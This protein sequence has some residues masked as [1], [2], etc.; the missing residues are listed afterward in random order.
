MRALTINAETHEIK[1]HAVDTSDAGPGMLAFMQKAVG[2]YI[3]RATE[4]KNGDSIFVNEEG[5]LE[6]PRFFFEVEGG[7]Q[8]FAG[9]GVVVGGEDEDPQP[10]P[11]RLVSQFPPEGHHRQAQRGV[12]NKL[13]RLCP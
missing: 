2:G 5:L 13:A 9:N 11:V 7:H 1:V 4:L 8:P 6:N 12:E 10:R 3:E